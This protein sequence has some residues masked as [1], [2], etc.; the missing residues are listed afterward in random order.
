MNKQMTPRSPSLPTPPTPLVPHLQP[1]VAVII[2]VFKHSG[3]LAEAIESVLAQKAD[4]QIA[5]VI[6]NDGC[7]FP[8]TEQVGQ[9]YAMAHDN[10]FYLRKANGGLSSARNFGIDFVSRTFPGFEAIYLLDA[11]NRITPSALKDLLAFLA[12]RP[13]IDWV[14][15]NID[16]FGIA[17][18]GNYTTEYSRLLHVTFDNICE[19]GSL[20]SRRLVDAGVRFDETMKSGFEDWDFWLQALD[21]GMKGANHPYFGFEYRQRAESML[22][23]SNR[24]RG[25]I[26]NY[27][28]LKHK[29]LFQTDTLLGFEHEEV[30]RYLH[31]AVGTYQVA[32]FT[33]PERAHETFR[34]DEFAR[35]FW[36]AR[37]E[38][39][40]FGTPPFMFWMA[41]SQ[42]EGLKRL[43]LYHNVLWLMERLAGRYNF[44]AVR[45]EAAR[46]KFEISV[47]PI[48]AE[49]PLGNKLSGWMTTSD[50]AAAC[51]EDRTDDWARTLRNPVPT[52]TV[53]ELV[54]RAP[55]SLAETQSAQLSP[56]NAL[57]ATIG[58]LRDSGYRIPGG[59]QKWV[60]RQPYLPNRSRYYDL[61]RD[62]SGTH[63]IM[64]RL[65]A[66]AGKLRVGMLLPVA[67]F[68]G[69]EKVAYAMA[70][71][72]ANA[73][74]EVHLFVLGKPLYELHKGNEDLFASINFLAAD[75][76]IWGGQHTYAGHELQMEGD[77]NAMAPD[78]LG[79]LNG[80]D[81]VIN[82]QVA[83]VN[84]V[85]GSLRR[86]GVKV[87]NYVHVLDRTAHGRDA[88]HPYLS[89]AF[90]HVY[91]AILT[92]SRDMVRWLQSMGVPAAK[93]RHVVN[94]PSYEMTSDE[95]AT[96]LT[97]RRADA[98]ERPLRAMFLGRF[99]AQKGI[100]RLHAVIRELQFRGVEVDWRV[101][102]RD[103]LDA[104]AG[105]SWQEK[106]REIGTTVLPP[107]YSGA[108]LSKAFTWA[109][110]V[111]LPSRWEGAPLTI[112]EAQRLGCLPIA[113]D[114]GAVSELI[115]DGH[116]G[117]LVGADSEGGI[118][119]Q[120]A[121]Q[122]TRLSADRALL[123]QMSEAGA[124]RAAKLNWSQSAEPLLAMVEEWFP[125]RMS[126]PRKTTRRVIQIKKD[127]KAAV[128][129]E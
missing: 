98:G 83:T 118:V 107:L 37:S 60:W 70:R 76:P 115:A 104:G 72:L 120:F 116:D 53:V 1:R 69:V 49:A 100:E 90:E 113:T 6:V 28:R 40:T 78:I 44:V 84:S 17:W 129:A 9:A 110:V 122:L 46:S 22:R 23:D 48:N 54:I 125:D 32:T 21:R 105:A 47:R 99:D 35:R 94:A 93:L 117:L 128:P 114:V 77:A 29:S 96:A 27:I 103:V 108:E 123:R 30:P 12:S 89:L 14:Y 81:L 4:F 80:L 95:V 33:D 55:F 2:P 51:A 43:K 3:L 127:R 26:L 66:Q 7:P 20:I 10:V 79:L 36:A 111:V 67:S 62:V 56:T 112:L 16:K 92:C 109:D 65:P 58:A 13:D 34:L 119:E 8:E 82:N 38:P 126:L 31:V 41:S 39:D 19:A 15:P 102:G 97:T 91:D 75:Y 74:C 88:G 64:P 68:G 101:V 106:F 11:D 57:L 50:V 52:P 85:L 124:E 59:A 71:V 73:G 63:A 86:R 87:I 5:I 18:S 121:A 45:L 42:T 24:T 61:L 25:T